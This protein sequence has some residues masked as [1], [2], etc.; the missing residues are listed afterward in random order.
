MGAVMQ[1]LKIVVPTFMLA[2]S[3]LAG[4]GVSAHSIKELEAMLGDREKYFQQVAREA[5]GFTLRTADGQSV[6]LDDLLGSVVVL[7]FI[8]ASCPDVCPLHAEKIAAIQEMVNQTPMKAQVQFVSITTD[9]VNDTTEVMRNYGPAHGLDP[10]NWN[11]LTTAPDQPED[12]TRRLAQSY[13]HRFAKTEGGAQVHG[14]V[15][16]V[17]DKNGRWRGN[18]HGLRFEPTNLVV[19]VNALVN[20]AAAAHGHGER[21]WLDKLKELF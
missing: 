20:D 19:F 7:H 13:G 17:I 14:V 1:F 6:R 4:T 5:P 11:F 9:P 16:H 10:V 18:F 21:S 8:Y 2:V 3:L 15:T 12:A